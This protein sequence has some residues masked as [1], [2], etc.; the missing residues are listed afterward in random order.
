MK[1][2]LATAVAAFVLTIFVFSP[3]EVFFGNALEFDAGLFGSIL[4]GV[5]VAAAVGLI[6]FLL[7]SI[8]IRVDDDQFA[9]RLPAVFMALAVGALLQGTYLG[10][11]FGALDGQQIDWSQPLAIALAGIAVWFIPFVAPLIFPNLRKPELVRTVSTFVILIQAVLFVVNFATKERYVAHKE[12]S[13]DRASMVEFSADQNAVVLVLDA[14]QCDVFSDVMVQHPSKVASY[15]GFTYFPN[16]VA[17]SSQTFP[18]LPAILTAQLYD[19]SQPTADYLEAAYTTSSLPSSLREAGIRTELFPAI[20]GTVFFTPDIA[21]NAIPREVSLAANWQVI[22]YGIKRSAPVWLKRWILES[23]AKSRRAARAAAF[24]EGRGF[25]TTHP[26][27]N[28]AFRERIPS[29]TVVQKPK[30][31]KFIHLE[32]IHVPLRFDEDMVPVQVMYSRDSLTAQAAGIAGLVSELLE[33]M[34]SL[35]V[36]DDS[37]IYIL[38]D[39]GSGRDEGTWVN[40]SDPSNVA[41]N[42]LK[43]RGC[44]LFLAKPPGASHSG[45]NV[46][47][48]PVDLTD[49][50]VSI[51]DDLGLPLLNTPLRTD[52]SSPPKPV[53]SIS[54]DEK[55]VRVYYSYVWERFNSEY[56]TPMQGYLIEG[57]VRDDANWRLGPLLVADP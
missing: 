34:K 43:A 2:T 8:L 10:W 14:F 19:N 53:F 54:E 37:A 18:S 7:S 13:V 49:V 3:S 44:P 15:D 57:D 46:S 39:H 55:R 42:Q 52:G 12:Y 21:D 27:D 40:P 28:L 31:F 38:G 29:A 48:A 32:G 51:F 23:E 47:L 5:A 45:I 56:L 26:W 22:K 25:V 16:A 35:G 30:T 33:R 1:S 41:F 24:R 9:E 20:N 36:Y 6:L 11:N 50:P 4:T 17:S